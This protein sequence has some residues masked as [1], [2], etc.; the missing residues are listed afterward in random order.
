MI[1][2]NVY[3]TLADHIASVYDFNYCHH[4]GRLSV[5]SEYDSQSSS[6]GNT[7]S[8]DPPGLPIST[9]LSSG[10]P[11]A[12]LPSPLS[13]FSSYY[14]VPPGP[15]TYC[16][17]DRYPIWIQ[18]TP[19][20][21]TSDYSRWS[22][23]IRS[24]SLNVYPAG[25]S[26]SIPDRAGNYLGLNLLGR[27][28]SLSMYQSS[29]PP[30]LL[31]SRS[32]GGSSPGFHP[33][34]PSPRHSTTVCS[35]LWGFSHPGW[36]GLPAPDCHPRLALSTVSY[37]HAAGRRSIWLPVLSLNSPWW[38]PSWRLGAPVG[39]STSASGWRGGIRSPSGNP[40]WHP[41]RGTPHVSDPWSS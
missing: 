25:G 17:L 18:S 28:S 27:P 20:F 10:L 39:T 6:L 33:C 32:G 29:P 24:W 22:L 37:S 21:S 31:Y 34:P 5:P 38:P 1:Y 41:L 19:G 9:I 12:R 40:Q 16:R 8:W 30:S 36:P 11:W 7:P 15:A 3:S 4:P 26:R 13:A 2:Y 35:L 23:R 14:S